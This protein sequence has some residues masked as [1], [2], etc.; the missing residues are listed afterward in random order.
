MPR[1]DDGTTLLQPRPVRAASA[2]LQSLRSDAR[3][4]RTCSGRKAAA[5]SFTDPKAKGSGLTAIGSSASASSPADA[6]SACASDD[7]DALHNAD[8]STVRQ[9]LPCS[10]ASPADECGCRTVP[11]PPDLFAGCLRSDGLTCCGVCPWCCLCAR[12][13]ASHA[14]RVAASSCGRCGIPLDELLFTNEGA[15]RG[16]GFSGIA[17]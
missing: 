6:L 9:K 8:P 5:Y 16:G 1:L 4:S 11:R 13:A 3:T 2:S 12:S 15:R 7:D 14:R 17:E 10:A